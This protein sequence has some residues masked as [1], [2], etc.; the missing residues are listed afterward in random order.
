MSILFLLLHSCREKINYEVSASPDMGNLSEFKISKTNIK[1]EYNIQFSERNN[2][3]LHITDSIVFISFSSENNE[4]KRILFK[5]DS[6]S[7]END[8]LSNKYDDKIIIKKFPGLV[9]DDICR[10]DILFDYD[11]AIMRPYILWFSFQ[12][13]FVQVI[14]GDIVCVEILTFLPD[15]KYRMIRKDKNAGYL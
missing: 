5:K 13:G 2:A 7:F 1:N 4:E 12:K 10:A 8:T 9:L 15:L 3:V 11:S 14:T 6:F